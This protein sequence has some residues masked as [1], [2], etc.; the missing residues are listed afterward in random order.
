MQQ[1]HVKQE[2]KLGRATPDLQEP[3]PYGVKSNTEI[4]APQSPVRKNET[5]Q[6]RWFPMN[7]P[8]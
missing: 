5:P 8:I 7:G 1:R 6:R 2:M 4:I 3:L